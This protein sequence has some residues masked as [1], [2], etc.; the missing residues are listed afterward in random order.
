MILP[1]MALLVQHCTPLLWYDF[2][3][4]RDWACVSQ[5]IKACFF[6]FFGWFFLIW[7]SLFPYPSYFLQT[8]SFKV[9]MIEIKLFITKSEVMSYVLHCIIWEETISGWFMFSDNKNDL[10][11]RVIIILLHSCIFF[12]LKSNV[13][14]FGNMKYLIL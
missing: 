14:C 2:D 13:C 4:S 9:L 12:P 5:N 1:L 11:I 8:D 6:F 10:W 3:F 7:I